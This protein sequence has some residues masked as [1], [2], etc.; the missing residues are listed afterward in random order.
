MWAGENIRYVVPQSI[1]GEEGATLYM[2]VREP[3]E[4]VRLRVGEVV[5]KGIRAVKPS[6]MVKIE[7]TGKE[8]GKVGE[9]VK[10][11]VI[12]CESRRS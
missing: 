1:S 2:R 7:L 12:D 10:E 8:L 3:R 5:S 6:E 11:L 9:D 4:K